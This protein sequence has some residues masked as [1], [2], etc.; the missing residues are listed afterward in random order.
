MSQDGSQAHLLL[1][2][3]GRGQWEAVARDW[4]TGDKRSQGIGFLFLSSGGMSPQGLRLPPD[5][6]PWANLR[7]PLLALVVPTINSVLAPSLSFLLPCFAR[8]GIAS[9]GL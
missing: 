1:P 7:F 6:L 2:L 9:P 3:G 5:T 8:L 4:R